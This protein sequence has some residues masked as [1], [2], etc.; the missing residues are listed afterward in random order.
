MKLPLLYLL[1]VGLP[2]AGLMA[3]LRL[4]T[5][6]EAPPAVGGPWKVVEGGR[7]SVPDSLFGVDQSGRFVHVVLPGRPDIPARL[8]G[9]ALAADGGARTD[10]SPGCASSAVRIRLRADGRVARRLVG[11]VGI[12]GCAACPET[13]FEAVRVVPDSTAPAATH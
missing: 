13:R 5:A 8:T 11:T 7:C 9:P 3:V 4:G 10:V 1:L 2:L 6:I 12:P